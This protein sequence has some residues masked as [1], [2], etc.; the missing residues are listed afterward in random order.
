MIRIAIFLVLTLLVSCKTP[1]DNPPVTKTE[2][3]TETKERPLVI[4]RNYEVVEEEA[5]SPNDTV[6]KNY[7]LGVVRKLDCGYVVDITMPEGFSLYFNPINLDPKF[8]IDGLRIKLKYRRGRE[9]NWG[10]TKYG[11]VEIVEAFIVR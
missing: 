11:Q 6:T 2:T 8:N 10:C 3:K 1:K 4:R 5:P 9:T 7:Y